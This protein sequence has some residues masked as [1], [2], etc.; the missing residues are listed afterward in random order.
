MEEK[1][2]VVDIDT[3]SVAKVKEEQNFVEL[4]ENRNGGK[5]MN[6]EQSMPKDVEIESPNEEQNETVENDLNNARLAS[7]AT[8]DRL[9]PAFMKLLQE[10]GGDL[11]SFYQ[12][13]KRL[14]ALPHDQRSAELEALLKKS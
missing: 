8:Y 13:C 1:T 12:A 9:V 7:V 6:D 5:V 10:S 2:R 11:K 3:N 4:D 14:G